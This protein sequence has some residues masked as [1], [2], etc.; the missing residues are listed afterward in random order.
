MRRPVM[1]SA[2]FLA[3]GSLV[4]PAAPA[5]AADP[6]L[7]AVPTRQLREAVTVNGILTHLRALQRI[8]NDNGGTRASGT[9]GYLASAQYVQRRLLAAGYS[10]ELQEFTF[11]YFEE[12]T[13]TTLAQTAPEA[14][15][16]ETEALEFSG[17]GTP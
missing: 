11:P 1:L 7:Q 14:V 10:V 8:A 12:V 9:P 17:D 15:D 13:P 16:Y 3:A 2:V 4:V 5:V 6:G